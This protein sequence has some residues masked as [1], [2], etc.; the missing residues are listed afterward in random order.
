M[1]NKRLTNIILSLAAAIVLYG[2][3]ALLFDFYYDLNDDVMIKDILAGIYTGRPDAHNNQML[4]P[5]SAVIA[6][7]Y[8]TNDK[9]PWF[10]LFEIICMMVSFILI[11]FRV[12][13]N[14]D[15]YD[16]CSCENAGDSD[17]DSFKESEH[18]GR[19]VMIKV[20]CM[21]FLIILFAGLMMWELVNI[22]YTVVAGILTATAAVMLYTGDAV[23]V[24]DEEKDSKCEYRATAFELKTFVRMNIP[25]IILVVI[26]FNIRSEL[27]L[28]LSPIL[29]AVAIAKWSEESHKQDAYVICGYLGVFLCICLLILCSLGIDRAAYSSPE[30]KE[31]RRFFDVRTELYDFTGVP[32]Y[33]ENLT[34][35]EEE[36]I[37]RNQYELLIDYNYYEDESID[38]DMLKRI[39]GGVKDGRATGR[40]TY[41]K[42]IREAVWEYIHNLKDWD[43]DYHKQQ[44][45][46][47]EDNIFID[48][49]MQHKPFN[50][51]IF[52][53]Y[54]E[55][56][57]VSYLIK[58]KSTIIKIPSFI[59]LRTIPWLFV[60][61]KGRVLSRI[62]HPLYITE[63]VILLCILLRAVLSYKA[64]T[65]AD[66]QTKRVVNTMGAISVIV[67]T[68]LCLSV[69]PLRTDALMAAGQAREEINKEAVTLYDHTSSNPDTYYYIDTYSTVDFTEKMFGVKRLMKKNTQLLGGWM[70]NSPLDT[71]KRS[72]CSS[73]E[74]ITGDKYLALTENGK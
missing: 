52:I 14:I 34:F 69:I 31:Y 61:L 2:A 22:Q 5:I 26:A 24:S 54:I 73:E 27:L 40:S 4:Y 7:L 72:F 16:L 33:D 9:V 71:Y 62:T 11:T 48:E 47:P 28:L 42:T 53:L 10:G 41:G 68:M 12:L 23:G 15:I 60:Y 32:D 29:A 63:I 65:D 66:M 46:S 43:I 70:G 39:V 17:S 19:T 64:S 20:I 8:R 25:S 1:R 38:A 50:V 55:I 56:I 36:G 67:I 58:E 45:V 30:W 37:T 57:A 18:T 44:G 74:I 49:S 35:Y 6:G 3:L 59:I 13:V 51:I 21:L